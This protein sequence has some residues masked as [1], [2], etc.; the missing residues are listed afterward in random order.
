MRLE[1]AGA[2]W[3]GNRI[4]DRFSP[5]PLRILSV[6]SMSNADAWDVARPP[7]K[8]AVIVFFTTSKGDSTVNGDAADDGIVAKKPRR[9]ALS[10]PTVEMPLLPVN[11]QC[12]TWR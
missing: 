6:R 11:G 9:T 4:E 12:K 1:E 2:A 8:G 5:P 3:D 7:E 10:T